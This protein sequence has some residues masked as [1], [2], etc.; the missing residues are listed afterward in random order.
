VADIPD[1]IV[2]KRHRDL[3][4]RRHQ[5][6]WRHA[7]V[8]LIAVFLLL[9]LLNVFGQAQDA[10]NVDSAPASLRL[11]APATVRGGLIYTV[12]FTITAHSA[13]KNAILELSPGW[14]EGVQINTIEPSPLGE[15]SRD[16]NLLLTLGHVP[17][18]TKY[19]LFM[20]F[21]TNPTNVGSRSADV[22]LYDG[23]K[24]LVHID[25]TLR[26]YP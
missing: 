15:A 26:S 19:V 23:G 24:R 25:R 17:K 20:G 1:R 22:T 5:I 9:G 11:D 18:G 3:V 6:W 14:A 21:Q 8:A 7:I 16:G 12:Q 4:G 2:L 13:L 10:T